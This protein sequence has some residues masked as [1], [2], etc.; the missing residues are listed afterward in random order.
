MAKG[1]HWWYGVDYDITFS[2]MVKPSTMHTIL[3]ITTLCMDFMLIESVG[4]FSSRSLTQDYIY[5]T[6]TYFYWSTTS[7][8]CVLAL[9]S[10]LWLIVCYH[11]IWFQRF[12]IFLLWYGL[13]HCRADDDIF[14]LFS[15]YHVLILLVY[16][17]EVVIVD[18]TPPLLSPF[19]STLGYEF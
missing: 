1:F 2:H 19:I 5:N 14:F 6:T 13:T 15:G 7:S 10:Y 3:S 4:C 9:V 11:S 17:V 16:V 8:S 12:N 18:H